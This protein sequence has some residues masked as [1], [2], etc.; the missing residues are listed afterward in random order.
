MTQQK[1]WW[2]ISFLS[3]PASQHREREK[4]LGSKDWSQQT[5]A[6]QAPGKKEL[7]YFQ[8]MGV[9]MCVYWEVLRATETLFIII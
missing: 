4:P 3:G 6:Q 1:P 2:L 5:F 9:F 7:C 8:W